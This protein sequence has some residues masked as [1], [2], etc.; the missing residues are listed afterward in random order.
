MRK[1]ARKRTYKKRSTGKRA[2]SRKQASKID[3][4]I[5][6]LMVIAVLLGVLIYTKSGVIGQNLSEILGGIMGIIRYVLP[7]GIFAIAIK[8]A[9]EDRDMLKSK[10]NFKRVFNF[11]Y[12][13]DVFVNKNFIEEFSNAIL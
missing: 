1:L 10:Q 4:A 3:L 9:C 2:S 7:I 11:E 12:S 5:V 8:I 6:I 13:E